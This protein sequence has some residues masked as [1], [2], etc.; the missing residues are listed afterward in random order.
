ML[1]LERLKFTAPTPIQAETIPI[2]LA[3][4]DVMG[5][6]QTGTGKT[7]AFGIPL[8]EK[9][10][11]NPKSAAL[12]IA[13]TRE[14]AAQILKAVQDLLSKEWVRQTVLLIG[15]ESMAVSTE[16]WYD[17]KTKAHLVDSDYSVGFNIKRP[18]HLAAI[19]IKDP[20]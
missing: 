5:S 7:A 10:L 2:A 12:I 16:V 6:A 3:G 11:A 1:S 14:L 8:V 20:S 4:K 9:L 19:F 13:P 18:A 15:G 17:R